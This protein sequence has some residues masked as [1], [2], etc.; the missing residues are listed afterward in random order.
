MMG[1]DIMPRGAEPQSTLPPEQQRIHDKCYHPTGIFLPFPQDAIARSIPARFETMVRLYPDRLAVLD[2]HE[3]LT[4]TE[5]NQ[6]ANRVARAVL[7]CRGATEEPVALLLG[8]DASM[9]TALL[10]VL[11]AG[12]MYVVLDPSFPEARTTYMLDDA[13]ARLLLTHD[14][15]LAL[16]TRVAREDCQ[17]LNLDHLGDG[18]ATENIGVAVAPDAYAFILYTSGSTG[19]P[20][21]VLHTHRTLL[22]EI[23]NYTNDL[24]ICPDDRL[25][26]WHSCSF[27]NSIRNMYGALL[28]GAAI[29]PYSLP[30]E[31]F[32]PLAQWLLQQRITIIHTLPTSFRR[33]VDTLSEQT[34]MPDLRLV[35]LG[36]EPITREDVKRFK[37]YF[38]DDCIL[39]HAMGPTETFT[40]GRH[41][42]M[43]DTPMTDS[44]VPVGYA[45][46]DKAILLF[47]E[48]G[49]EVG[50]NGVGEIAIASRYLS[51]G[52]WRRPDD[53]AT[54][55]VADPRGGSNR[56]YRTG[57]L[58]MMRSD[59][60]LLHMG[61]KDFQ[62]KIRGFRIDPTEIE[63][64]LL[65]LKHIKHAVVQAQRDGS[66]EPQLVAYLVPSSTPPPTVSELRRAL[67]HR[68][69]ADMIPSA[70]VMLESIPQTPTGKTDRQALPQRDRARPVLDAPF[71]PPRTPVETQ[72]ARLWA[73]VLSLDSVG[74]HDPFLELGGH[75]LLATQILT[76]IIET[77]RVDLPL[78]II[79]ETPTIAEMAVVITHHL[80]TRVAPGTAEG[81]LAE[82]EATELPVPL[83]QAADARA[84]FE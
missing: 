77:F 29:F 11:K 55:F 38:P 73:E 49:Q 76:R 1:V 13:Q 37:H 67:A 50:V 45:V 59:G 8:H 62:V 33:L 25:T 44:K 7:A 27:A 51:P 2:Q 81:L 21:G 31:G 64:T 82:V 60:C 24:H 36:G 71:I 72:L 83:P 84:R 53:T 68:L 66:D 22:V 79:L 47:D 43:K 15:H 61:R 18:L 26:L 42:I 28:N 35:R 19:K 74:V 39:M 69:P 9:I 70:F 52:Y 23:R 3:A 46:Q 48:A 54:A 75:S 5:L 41:F 40:I 6:R 30:Q 80:A 65:E 58:G 17:V 12:K 63:V 16:A 14:A 32:Q 20:K 57:D 34:T 56:V 4:Y 78:R 10:G